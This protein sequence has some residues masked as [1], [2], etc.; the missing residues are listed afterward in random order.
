MEKA[1][2]RAPELPE[3]RCRQ[4]GRQVMRVQPTCVPGLSSLCQFVDISI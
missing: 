4:G 3:S 2:A 1:L